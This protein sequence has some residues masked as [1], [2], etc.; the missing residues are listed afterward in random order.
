MSRSKRGE[1]KR[2]LYDP[3][4]ASR[5]GGSRKKGE[6]NK[7]DED[8]KFT[9]I[10]ICQGIYMPG[11]RY[12][13]HDTLEAYTRYLVCNIPGTKYYVPGTSFSCGRGVTQG[14]R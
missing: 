4:C 12:L 8:N 2:L 5:L 1:G 7:W 6:D 10:Y 3:G 13:V 14:S 9:R 11:T